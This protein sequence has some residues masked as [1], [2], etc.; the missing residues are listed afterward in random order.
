MNVLV[1]GSKGFIGTNLIVRLN[2]LRIQVATYTRE[3]SIQDLKD[4][5]NWVDQMYWDWDR[6][7]SS[8][9]E[10]LDKSCPTRLRLDH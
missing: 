10:T 4:L 5:R 1:T 6:M 7:S 8:G 3:N 9:Q 2:E